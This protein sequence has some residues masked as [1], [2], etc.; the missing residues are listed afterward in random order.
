MAKYQH[1]VEVTFTI[2][3]EEHLDPEAAAE[4]MRLRI[5]MSFPEACNVRAEAQWKGTA[6]RG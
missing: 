5:K 1:R 4:E 2:H 3:V 6:R